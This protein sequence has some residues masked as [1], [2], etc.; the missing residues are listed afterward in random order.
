MS[1]H[2]RAV[3]LSASAQMERCGALIC[4]MTPNHSLASGIAFATLAH[5]QK[6]AS[7][8]RVLLCSSPFLAQDTQ[9]GKG[10]CVGHSSGLGR[11]SGPG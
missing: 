6:T 5:S 8:F 2:V 11:A 1:P 3:A 10:T 9:A 4:L 7:S